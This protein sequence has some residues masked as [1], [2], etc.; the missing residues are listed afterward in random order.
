MTLAISVFMPSSRRIPD[1]L[2][3]K[4][5]LSMLAIFLPLQTA[6]PYR[7]E[8]TEVP[9]QIAHWSLKDNDGT[10]VQTDRKNFNVYRGWIDLLLCAD[11]QHNR[12][13]ERLRSQA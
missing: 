3:K 11:F 9:G 7:P 1:T 8:Y 12:R 10:Q 5:L 6:P 4:P 13:A 2:F